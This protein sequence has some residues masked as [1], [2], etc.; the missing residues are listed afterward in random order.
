MSFGCLRGDGSDDI[1]APPSQ[2]AKK[3]TLDGDDLVLDG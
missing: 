1:H 2:M 3:K